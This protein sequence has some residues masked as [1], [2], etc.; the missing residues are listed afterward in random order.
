[1]YLFYILKHLIE[2]AYARYF[3][4]KQFS[5]C[6]FLI[7]DIPFTE[8]NER[9][10]RNLT[11]QNFRPALHIVTNHVSGEMP[12]QLW[13]VCVCVHSGACRAVRLG[14]CLITRAESYGLHG[15]L[16]QLQ[17]N[18]EVS[19]LVAQCPRSPALVAFIK[20]LGFRP[21]CNFPFTRHLLSAGNSFGPK[22]KMSN[23]YLLHPHTRACAF[24]SMV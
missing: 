9:K 10:K 23:F 14:G 21:G 19:T 1:M 11:S 16:G 20:T 13:G 3:F 22:K 8:Y 12:V 6:L 15:D 5:I 17:P 2:K 7:T 4:L 18:P 24:L